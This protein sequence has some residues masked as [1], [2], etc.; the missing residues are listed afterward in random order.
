MDVNTF[1]NCDPIV[2]SVSAGSDLSSTSS[3]AEM[4]LAYSD[5]ISVLRL[6]VTDSDFGHYQ[7]T[8]PSDDLIY[9][10]QLSVTCANESLASLTVADSH[11][12]MD[13]PDFLADADLP[14]VL[15][16]SSEEIPRG[17]VKFA[18][19]RNLSLLL[20]HPEVPD[21]ELE[22][23]NARNYRSRFLV[24]KSSA[25]VSDLPELFTL[26]DIARN[27]RRSTDLQGQA[28][29][30]W[31]ELDHSQII[32]MEI[33]WNISVIFILL[34]SLTRLLPAVKSLQKIIQRFLVPLTSLALVFVNFSRSAGCGCCSSGSCSAGC[35]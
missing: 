23:F 13:I 35:R 33:A 17:L 1:V 29:L 12:L 28:V 30:E 19:D 15:R 7:F 9:P 18:G 34:F 4:R 11:A 20:V 3:R 5:Y 6:I 14:P 2:R 21:K 8:E 22:I 24:V 10:F 16:S 25:D 26:V 32:D 31:L 27:F